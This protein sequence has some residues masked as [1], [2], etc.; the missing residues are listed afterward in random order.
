MYAADRKNRKETERP[1]PGYY[2]P[3]LKATVA[4]L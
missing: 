1:E 3:D 2:L 4:P